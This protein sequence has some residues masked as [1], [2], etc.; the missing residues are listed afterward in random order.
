MEENRKHRISEEVQRELAA[1]LRELKDPRVQGMVTITSAEVTG[2]LKF[3]KVFV[4]VLEQEREKDVLKGLRSA[5]G[6]LRRELGSR[7]ELRA[8]PQLIFEA[9]DSIRHGA[10]INR[11]LKDLEV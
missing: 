5:S 10:N 4:S 9:D 1:L 8:V 3:C 2:D 7:I 11:I 6:W